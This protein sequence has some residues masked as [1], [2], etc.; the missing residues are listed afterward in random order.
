MI[1]MTDIGDSTRDPRGPHVIS[2]Y[3]SYNKII[4]KGTIIIQTS[5]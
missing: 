5:L 4:I 2:W 3:W 1:K